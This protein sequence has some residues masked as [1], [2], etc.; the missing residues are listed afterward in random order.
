MRKEDDPAPITM[1]ARRAVEAG[2]ADEE[3]LLD[4]EAGAQMRRERAVL[5]ND[6][7]E[8]DDPLDAGV[9]RRLGEARRHLPVA[10]GEAAVAGRRLHGVH[11]VVGGRASLERLLQAGAG[12][13]VAAHDLDLGQALRPTRQRAHGSPLRDEAAQQAAA[14]VSGC[15]GDQLHVRATLLSKIRPPEKRAPSGASWSDPANTGKRSLASGAECVVRW[16]RCRRRSP[17]A[18]RSATSSRTCCAPW[19]SGSR[20]RP[21]VRR[22]ADWPLSAS[23]PSSFAPSERPPHTRFLNH[24]C[25][26]RG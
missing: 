11:E 22:S 20:A 12:E 6:S 17:P 15:S 2:T 5:R 4:L 1:D 7:S 13:E 18:A 10:A 16:L 9:R 8:V 19:T 14:D 24:A 23:S 25:K 3:D 26:S 21:S